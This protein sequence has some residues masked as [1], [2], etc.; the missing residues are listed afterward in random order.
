MQ[1]D[2]IAKYFEYWKTRRDDLFWA[3]QEVTNKVLYS[4]E[5]AW[6]IVLELIRAAPDDAAI[7]YVAAGPLED[8]LCE[9]GESFLARLA[10]VAEND[11]RT[12]EALRAVWGQNRMK[13]SVW[14]EVQRLA[15]Q[16]MN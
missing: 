16:V 3:W 8:L 1:N 13:P 6:P 5:E 10:A 11:R 14:S 2:L 7:C 12:R 9:H 4:P 15:G